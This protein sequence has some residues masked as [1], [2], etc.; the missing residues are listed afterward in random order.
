MQILVVGTGYVGLVTGACLAEMGH[1]VVCLDIDKTKIANL[2]QS[3]L[4]IFEPGLKEIVDRNVRANRLSFTTDYSE[5]VK[6]AAVF[7]LAVPTP[8]DEDG[9]CD[10]SYVLDAASQIAEEISDYALIVCKSTVPVGS[11][12]AIKDRVGQILT[13]RG[14]AISFDVVSNPEFL[15][16]GSAVP[17]CMKPDRIILGVESS[18]A[19]K[20]MREIYSAFTL[21]H[22]R[23][24]VMDIL[25][26]E[27]TK[28][29]ANAMLATRI[30]FM[31][32]L[33]GLC[34]KTGADIHQVR[35]GIGSDSRIGYHF[36]YAGAGYGGSC[37]PKDIRALQA[38]AKQNEHHAP[39]L[40]AVESI[41]ERQKRVLGEKILAYFSENGGAKGKTVAIWGLSFKPD[42]DDL[43]E[44]PSLVLIDQL[45]KAGI[46]L[47]LYDPISMTKA[48]TL[49]TKNSEI[50]WCEDEYQAAKDADAI[51]LVTEWK[52][53]RFVDFEALAKNLRGKAFFDGRNQYKAQEMQA[54]GFDYFGIGIPKETRVSDAALL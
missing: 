36:L 16:E 23:I 45:L 27:M 20:L 14:A 3:I 48:R 32:E 47:K 26:S 17:D 6:G 52:Q 35:V 1:H 42:T 10:L 15:K 8:S 12:H 40:A 29:A 50:E 54:R 43:R 41:N 53:F 33:A 22:D 5:G 51:A 19:E 21:S 28:Y 49:L 9:S 2:K 25:S 39:L 30:S 34:E 24:L 37:F 44:A 46:R 13:K 11:C 18:K 7:F 31:N 38:C 4:P